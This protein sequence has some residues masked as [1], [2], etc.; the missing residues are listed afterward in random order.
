MPHPIQRMR[1]KAESGKHKY[2]NAS[3]SFAFI[4]VVGL[5]FDCGCLLC[6][7][8]LVLVFVCGWRVIASVLVF[9]LSDSGVAVW[10]AILRSTRL[11]RAISFL[12]ASVC[13]STAILDV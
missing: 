7:V 5:L 8:V 2:F 1:Q 6:C 4:A 12:L 9:A 11:L 10:I 3:C 13:R